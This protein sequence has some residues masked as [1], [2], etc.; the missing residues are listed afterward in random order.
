MQSPFSFDGMI[1]FGWLS[2]MLLT[3]VL[4]RSKTPLL[5]RF[6]FP[7][8]LT[9]GMLGLALIQT[10]IIQ[11][12]PGALETYAYHFFNISF[13]SVG[14]TAGTSRFDPA[15]TK[16]RVHQRPC[17]DGPDTGILFRLASI[18]GRIARNCFWTF[19]L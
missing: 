16:Q 14:L 7:S 11:I 6:L 15:D 10:G 9:G 3:G 2:F 12:D 5:Q 13:I 4:L 1:V 18:L 19:R 17:L 8:C